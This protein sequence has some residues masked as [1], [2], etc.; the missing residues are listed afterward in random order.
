MSIIPS[1]V[2]LGKRK[3][4][5]VVFNQYVRKYFLKVTIYICHEHILINK[6]RDILKLPLYKQILKSMSKRNHGK[7]NSNL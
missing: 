7:E 4:V 1:L 5:N 2:F 3:P 6:D